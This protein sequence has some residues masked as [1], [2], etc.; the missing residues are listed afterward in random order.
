MLLLL[1]C[2][3]PDSAAPETPDTCP[4]GDPE[5]VADGF[6]DGTEGITWSGGALYVSAPDTLYRLEP[7]GAVAVAE[8][9]T[10]GLAPAVDGV[11]A[12]AP[13][14]F[15]LDGSGDDGALLHISADGDVTTLADG[16]PNPNAVAMIEGG[17]LLVSDDTAAIYRDGAVWSDAVPSPNGM[18]VDGD[19]LY[20]VSTFVT[21]PPL[22]RVPITDGV[23]GAPVEV[24][25]FETGDT[26]DGVALD[27][28]S[29]LWVALNVPGAIVRV[30][31]TDGSITDRIEGFATPASLSFGDVATDPCTLYV[32]ELYGER[33]WKVPVPHPGVAVPVW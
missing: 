27:T 25:R 23:A 22:W 17:T 29:G 20:V 11:I 2:A 6:T 32:T 7:S 12:A 28:E 14:D 16:M 30:D 31:L 24:T 19:T 33:V 10:L 15:T 3:G 21:E 4:G 13:G 9:H 5:P 1:A 8:A 26:P 18:V